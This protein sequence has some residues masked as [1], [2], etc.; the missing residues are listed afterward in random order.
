M[1]TIFLGTSAFSILPT[2]K[3]MPLGTGI[4]GTQ[5]SPEDALFYANLTIQNA[6]A[7][8]LYWIARSSD[9]TSVLASGTIAEGDNVIENIPGYES[10]MLVTVRIRKAGY[11]PFETQAN[12]I[13]SGV[14]VYV[15]Q[16]QD[17]VYQA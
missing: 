15:I 2:A 8:S 17:T 12:L 10:P 3:S 4:I 13:S 5:R 11:D 6:I 16:Q 14:G 1:S 9:L 7:D